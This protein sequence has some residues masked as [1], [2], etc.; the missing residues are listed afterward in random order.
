MMQGY[1]RIQLYT[2]IKFKTLGQK[3]PFMRFCLIFIS[4][5]IVKQYHTS[6]VFVPNTTSGN[7]ILML[8]NSSVLLDTIM[9]IL[10][11]NTSYKNLLCNVI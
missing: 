8:Y 4:N 3:C 10:C 6:A 9:S 1:N 7:V 11:N 2:P 5:Y